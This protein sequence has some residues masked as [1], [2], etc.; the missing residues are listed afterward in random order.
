M[1]KFKVVDTSEFI[2]K[3]GKLGEDV[4]VY[5]KF[6]RDWKRMILTDIKFF[7]THCE[8]LDMISIVQII[9]EPVI[10]K[11]SAFFPIDS[12]KDKN[13]ETC[14]DIAKVRLIN[15][16][17]RRLNRVLAFIKAT[18]ENHGNDLQMYKNRIDKLMW[19]K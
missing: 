14:K 8:Y 16:Y 11:G 17:H 10:M 9:N 15:K 7:V 12:D 6:S 4:I 18:I 5:A 2:C 19:N 1:I 3:N 13:I